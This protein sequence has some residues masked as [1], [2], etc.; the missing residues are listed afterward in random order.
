MTR[1][2]ENYFQMSL[3]GGKLNGMKLSSSARFEVKPGNEQRN[4]DRFLSG[5]SGVLCLRRI[6]TPV[7]AHRYLSLSR[8]GGKGVRQVSGTAGA[9]GRRES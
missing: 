2:P 6:S 7:S 4:L 9:G 3:A 8:E 5:L 1:E